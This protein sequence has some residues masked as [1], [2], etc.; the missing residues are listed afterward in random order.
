MNT[1]STADSND[2]YWSQDYKLR[3]SDFLVVKKLPNN[4]LATLH[5]GIFM[6]RDSVR[7]IALAVCD[8]RK[9]FM[10]ERVKQG[11]R[12]KEIINHEQG[13]FDIAEYV[14]RLLNLELINV[15]NKDIALSLYEY[16]LEMLSTMQLTYDAQTNNSNDLEWQHKWDN[17]LKDLL[18]QDVPS[19]DWKMYPYTSKK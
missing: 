2:L 16:H 9:S 13:H 8:R 4:K 17:K 7:F 10:T 15:K 6:K 5:S 11:Y 19:L 3:V 12:L 1:Y 14:A 18:S